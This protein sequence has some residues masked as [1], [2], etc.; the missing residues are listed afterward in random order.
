MEFNGNL[1]TGLNGLYK[2]VYTDGQNVTKSLATTQF[3]STYARQAVPCFDEPQFK[4]TFN[5]TVTHS[6]KYNALSNM[7]VTDTAINIA[8][9]TTVTKFDVSVKMVTYLVALVVSE[10]ECYKSQVDTRVQVCAAPGNQDKLEYA[11]ERTPQILRFF[12]RD[13]FEIDYPLPKL[14]NIAIPDF[15]AG[16]M[17]NWGLV[18]YREVYLFYDPSESSTRDQ[19]RVCMIISHELAHMVSHL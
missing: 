8:E 16:A 6:S 2:S 13:Y 3:E 18:T 15:S 11:N 5:I 17:E 9:D 7:P 19:M 14:D 10:F 4:S 12:E 1:S